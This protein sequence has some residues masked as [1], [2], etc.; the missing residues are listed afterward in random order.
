MQL[1]TYRTRTVIL[2]I[3]SLVTIIFLIYMFFYIKKQFSITRSELTEDM[4]IEKITSMGKLELVKYTMKDVLERKEFRMILPDKRILF[5]AA[6]EVTG[7]IDLSKVKK[8][9]IVQVGAD[10]V[11]ITLP[12]PEIC[13]FKLDHQRSKVYDITGVWFPG[14]SKDMVEGIY[15]IAEKKMLQNASEQDILGKTKENANLIF[16]PMLE[17][18][19]GKR[20]GVT[21]K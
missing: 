2:L 18:I 6:G 7:C 21:F 4:M 20:V 15:Q 19:T 1:I 17:N 12:Q 10:S 14:D 5:V 13:Y 9:D 11:T 8:A 16:K 3:S